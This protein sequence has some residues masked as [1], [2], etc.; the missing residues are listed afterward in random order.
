MFLELEEAID[1]QGDSGNAQ[2][3][4]H[5]SDRAAGLP[6]D[7]VLEWPQEENFDRVALT[8]HNLEADTRDN[9][10]HSGKRVSA[11][12]ARDYDLSVWAG[13]EWRE[14]A[15]VTDNFH[16]RRVHDVQQLTTDKL[17]LRVHATHGEGLGARVYEVRV[18]RTDS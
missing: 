12:L 16:R 18:Y 13:G 9:P 7:L 1:D 17:R 11:M 5:V 3:D 8:F 15:A 4:D 10:W 6:Q 2:G 14:V